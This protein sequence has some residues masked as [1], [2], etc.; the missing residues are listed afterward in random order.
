[1]TSDD[2]LKKL[3]VESLIKRIDHTLSFTFTITKLMYL[4][5]GAGL[6]FIYFAFNRVCGM[7]RESEW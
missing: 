2:E 6:A 4:V 3:K 5:N 7:R 1:M